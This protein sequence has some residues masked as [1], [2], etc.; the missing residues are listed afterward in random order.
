MSSQSSLLIF[1]QRKPISLLAQ[2]AVPVYRV[3]YLLKQKIL[4]S[5]GD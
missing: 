2:G 5:G 4:Y 1:F 3:Q